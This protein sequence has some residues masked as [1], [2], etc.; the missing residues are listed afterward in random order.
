MVIEPLIVLLGILVHVVSSLFV[1]YFDI[2][3]VLI[4]IEPFSI[5]IGIIVHVVLLLSYVRLF[6]IVMACE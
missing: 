1:S 2:F 5:I 6:A 3:G 4:P